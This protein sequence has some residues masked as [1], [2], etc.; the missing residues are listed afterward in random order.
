MI[1]PKRRERQR[2]GI[3]RAPARDFQRHHRWVRSLECV[4]PDCDCIQLGRP[5]ECCHLRLGTDGGTSIKPSSWW[6]YPGC[7]HHHAES[8][9][10]GE[11]SFQAKYKLDL[12]AICLALAK[13]SPDT[14]MR[15]AMREA[16]L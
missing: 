14:A 3:Q 2:S 11:A 16:G 15:D 13:Q 12:R 5:I 10:I 4:V 1:L 8:H 9:R 6:T 7:S